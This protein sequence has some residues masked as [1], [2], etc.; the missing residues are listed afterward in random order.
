MVVPMLR[1]DVFGALASHAGDA[2]FEYCYLPEFPAIARRLR[3]DFGG[4][5][6]ELLSKMRDAPTFD[7]GRFGDAFSMYAY[8]TIRANRCC[9]S[10]RPPAV[11]MTRFGSAGWRSIPSGWPSP[12]PRP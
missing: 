3:D 9:P 7:W 5:F 6:D 8:A 11:W 10:T 4:S 12:M 2:L 1:P